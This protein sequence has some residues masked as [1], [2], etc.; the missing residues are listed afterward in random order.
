MAAT[1]PKIEICHDD[2]SLPRSVASM[3]RSH[4]EYPL[5]QPAP[6]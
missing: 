1:P 5:G 6:L 2:E 3:A 4:N